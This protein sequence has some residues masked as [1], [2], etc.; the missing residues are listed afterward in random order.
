MYLVDGGDIRVH[1]VACA[2]SNAPQPVHEGR[3]AR[4]LEA[5]EADVTLLSE[6]APGFFSAMLWTY[7]R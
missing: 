2:T 5:D 1:E 6:D 7:G 3:L 4:V